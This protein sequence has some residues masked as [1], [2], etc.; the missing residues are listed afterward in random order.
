MH[1]PQ[2]GRTS[3]DHDQRTSHAR[4]ASDL[5][6]LA[7]TSAQKPLQLPLLVLAL[8]PAAVVPQPRRACAWMRT[9]AM[10]QDAPYGAAPRRCEP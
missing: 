8:E 4:C 10:G 7:S 5:L 9:R 1:R 2:R 3:H 6:Y